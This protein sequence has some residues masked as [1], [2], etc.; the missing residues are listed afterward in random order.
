MH[1]HRFDSVLRRQDFE[2]FLFQQPLHQTGE[3]GIVL[4][5]EN[6]LTLRRLIFYFVLR[7]S[8]G[9][10]LCRGLVSWNRQ[11]NMKGRTAAGFT[12]YLDEA[13]MF[14]DDIVNY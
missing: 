11:I 10:V 6:R 8:R 14:I 13:R 7:Q 3:P 5:I 9:Y 2:S 1:F 12:G 4:G